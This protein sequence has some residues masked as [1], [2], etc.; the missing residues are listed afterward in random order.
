LPQ[1]FGQGRRLSPRLPVRSG[2]RRRFRPRLS[3]CVLPWFQGFS[4]IGECNRPGYI[5]RAACTLLINAGQTGFHFFRAQI[6][7]RNGDYDRAIPDLSAFIELNPS[8]VRALNDRALSY[9]K[10]GEYDKAIADYSEVIRLVKNSD[11]T[12]YQLFSSY[13]LDQGRYRAAWTA[14]RHTQELILD[15]RGV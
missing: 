5:R 9:E 8:N 1:W 6:Y 12:Y 4:E 7:L 11:V 2:Q 13:R 14:Q 10:I 3:T 15:G